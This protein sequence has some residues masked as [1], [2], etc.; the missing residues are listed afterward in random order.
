M[1]ED[2][3]AFEWPL[4]R[5]KHS[6]PKDHYPFPVLH[7]CQNEASA[8]LEYK[9]IERVLANLDTLEIHL[10]SAGAISPRK[11]LVF[12]CGE[13]EEEDNVKAR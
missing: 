7:T 8:V 5:I 4:G 1:S 3:K 11:D 2:N 9:R 12:H 6:P 10:L 13:K